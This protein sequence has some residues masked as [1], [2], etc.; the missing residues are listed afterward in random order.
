MSVHTGVKCRKGTGPV[1][2]DA[3]RPDAA[4]TARAAPAEAVRQLGI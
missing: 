3:W 2:G 4:A 1:D